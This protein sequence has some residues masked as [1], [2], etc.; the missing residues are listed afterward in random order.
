M[1]GKPFHVNPEKERPAAGAD[2]VERFGS[3]VVNL[4]HILSIDP[5]PVLRLEN[6]QRERIRLARGH[7]DAIRV[8]FDEKEQREFLLFSK[9]DRFKKI[10]LP[11]RSIADGGHNEIFFAIE[12]NAPGDAARREQLRSGRRGHTP[13][14]QV[15]IAVM[16][17]HLTPAAPGVFLGKIFEA[18]LTR[19]HAAPEH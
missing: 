11:S 3:R 9:T 17:R 7:A 15:C 8:V 6:I 14:V 19:G 2:L 5:A 12:L 18:E 1:A 4:L 10:S 16:R 13:N